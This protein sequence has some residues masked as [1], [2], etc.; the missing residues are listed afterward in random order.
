[1]TA[2]D[3][4]TRSYFLPFAPSERRTGLDRAELVAFL[5][6]TDAHPQLRQDT[7]YT[8]SLRGYRGGWRV[9]FY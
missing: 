8:L 9:G 4:W 5:L 3:R 1:M 7:P 2:G 6:F